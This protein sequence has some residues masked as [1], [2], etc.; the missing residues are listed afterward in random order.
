MRT[1]VLDSK[2]SDFHFGFL[3][4]GI[5]DVSANLLYWIHVLWVNTKLNPEIK[6]S[7]GESATLCFRVNVI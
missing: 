2:Y 3:T 1:K 7:G 5:R 4:F 6:R